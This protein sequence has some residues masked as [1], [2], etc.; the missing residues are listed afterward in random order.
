MEECLKIGQDA[1][2]GWERRVSVDDGEYREKPTFFRL[3][4]GRWKR[5]NERDPMEF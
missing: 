4:L 3:G 5:S 2:G 1:R